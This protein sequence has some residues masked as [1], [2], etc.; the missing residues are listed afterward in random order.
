MSQQ[1]FID[2]VVFDQAVYIQDG[3]NEPRK[4]TAH[5]SYVWGIPKLSALPTVEAG[6]TGTGTMAAGDYAVFCIPYSAKFHARGMPFSD[7]PQRVTLSGGNN[8]IDVINLPT[9]SD[10][11][12]SHIMVFRTMRNEAAPFYF[13]GVVQNGEL[14][15]SLTAGDDFLPTVDVLE[16]PDYGTV[17]EIE[18]SMGGP[19]RYGRVP[20]KARV[21]AWDDRIW[22][23]GEV[24]YTKGLATVDHGSA[25]VKGELTGWYSR[26]EGRRFQIDGEDMAYEILAVDDANHLRLSVPYSDPEQQPVTTH[27]SS[28]LADVEDSLVSYWPMDDGPEA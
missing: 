10:T 24:P 17:D 2:H 18:L 22:V 28:S 11:N 5:G 3:V 15:L 20:V 14:G 23:A 4:I 13:A 27:D 16:P 8:S 9:M 25:L 26:L 6:N 21:A 7:T 19:F 12:I 1:A